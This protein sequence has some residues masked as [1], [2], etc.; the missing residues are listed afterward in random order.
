MFYKLKK[1]NVYITPGVIFY[2]GSTVGEEY[3]K[4]GFS[5][6]NEE[7][8]KRGIQLIKEELEKWHI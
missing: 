2:R 6:V 1:R 8:I 4:I 5:Q 3:F 7:E